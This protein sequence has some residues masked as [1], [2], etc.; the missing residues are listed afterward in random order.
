M[1]SDTRAV[2]MMTQTSSKT[3]RYHQCVSILIKGLKDG[4]VNIPTS[5]TCSD[6]CKFAVT[7][8]CVMHHTSKY[9]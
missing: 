1:R 3:E 8:T 9:V 4:N 7:I 2:H 5:M 6:H